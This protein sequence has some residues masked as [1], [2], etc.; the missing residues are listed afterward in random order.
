[1]KRYWKNHR[2]K[3]KKGVNA[4]KKWEIQAKELIKEKPKIGKLMKRIPKKEEKTPGRFF[5]E[6]KYDD[7]ASSALYGTKM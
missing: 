6:Q 7:P 5:I 3:T 4:S 2:K 1:M